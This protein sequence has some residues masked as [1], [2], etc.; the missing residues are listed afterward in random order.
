MR[1]RQWLATAASA[2]PF[3]LLLAW[4]VAPA[5]AI[6]GVLPDLDKLAPSFDL[7]GV[8]PPQGRLHHGGLSAK[9]DASPIPVRLRSADF[10]GRWLVLYFYP[11]DFT[12]GCTLE[13]RSFQAALA[14]FQRLNADVVGISADAAEAHVSFCAAEGLTYPLLSDPGGSVSRAYGSWLAPYSQRHTFL[15]DPNGQLR[16]RWLGV[17]PLGHGQEVRAELHR[18]QQQAASPG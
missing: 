5:K 18:L 3:G 13:A 9:G 6:G 12:S 11:K 15:I 7:D 4:G 16:S 10:Q 8:A 17:R 2:L 14:D 1:R